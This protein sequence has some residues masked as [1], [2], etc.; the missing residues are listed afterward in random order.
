MKNAFFVGRA[1]IFAETGEY[2]A[3]RARLMELA[4]KEIRSFLEAY[5]RPEQFDVWDLAK[6]LLRWSESIVV[7]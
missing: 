6:L 7:S 3:S 2:L 4:D 1:L 5:D